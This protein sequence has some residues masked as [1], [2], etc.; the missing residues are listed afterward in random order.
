MDYIDP[1]KVSPSNYK[2]LFE[3]EE[4]KVIEMSLKVGEKD[5][6]HSHK[7]ECVYFISGGKV[8]VTVGG[9]SQELE[10]PDGH[11]MWHEPWTHQVENIGSTDVKAI[12]WEK[13]G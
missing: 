8:K 11:V 10:I 13:K 6:E 9:E 5:E 3:N 2:V 1:A 7:T 12:I 4:V